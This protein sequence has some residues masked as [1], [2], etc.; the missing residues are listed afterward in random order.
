MLTSASAWIWENSERHLYRLAIKNMGKSYENKLLNFLNKSWDP[1]HTNEH[2]Y[3]YPKNK[4]CSYSNVMVC[5][6]EFKFN[7]KEQTLRSLTR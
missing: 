3:L 5:W 7:L 2:M 1:E 6:D 4:N